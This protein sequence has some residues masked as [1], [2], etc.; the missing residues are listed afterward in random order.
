MKNIELHLFSSYDLCSVYYNTK[1]GLFRNASSKTR[2][3]RLSHV[4][5]L[6]YFLEFFTNSLFKENRNSKLSS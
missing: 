1:I 6:C 3:F 4:P 2:N 5:I